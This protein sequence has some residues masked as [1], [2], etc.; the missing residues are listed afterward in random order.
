[1]KECKFRTEDG[2]CNK[3][4]CIGPCIPTK[5]EFFGENVG[6]L[7]LDE[8]CQHSSRYGNTYSMLTKE[9]VEALQNGKVLY[10][11]DGEYGHFIMLKGE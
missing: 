11:D 2:K 1:M 3:F 10:I 4:L 5:A 9:E 6:T 8:V 7:E